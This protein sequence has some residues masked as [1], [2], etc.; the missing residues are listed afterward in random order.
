M[1]IR[2]RK[3]WREAAEALEKSGHD[4]SV[5]GRPGPSRSKAL[6]RVLQLLVESAVDL[7]PELS[8]LKLSPGALAELRKRI[9]G[10]LRDAAARAAQAGRRELS[11][12]DV[13]PPPVR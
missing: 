1:V 11:A 3:E 2:V 13:S 4:L 8:D 9:T 6:D 7:P 10:L 12:E 5:V